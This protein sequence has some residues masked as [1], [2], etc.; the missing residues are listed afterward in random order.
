MA[1]EKKTL[2]GGSGASTPLPAPEDSPAMQKY[3]QDRRVIGVSHVLLRLDVCSTSRHST[4]PS[5]SRPFSV[6][7]SLVRLLS[8]QSLAHV[9]PPHV[10]SLAEM[11]VLS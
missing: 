2:N 5:F 9:T 11:T 4:S 3:L 6:M 8:K 10:S 1:I 7:R